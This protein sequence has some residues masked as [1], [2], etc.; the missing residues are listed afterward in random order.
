MSALL[1][2][3]GTGSIG[4]FLVKELIKN[5]VDKEIILFDLNPNYKKIKEISNQVKVVCGD[6][7]IW[8]DLVNIV[9]KYEVS[10]IF[11][12]AAILSSESERS[13]LQSMRVNIKGTINILEVA[14]LFNINKV[15]FPSTISTYG[16]NAVEPVDENQIQQ[17]TNIY[18]V[19]KVF[20]ELWGLYYYRKYRID[21][22]SVRFPRIVNPGRTGSGAA[23][24]P[25]EL[26]EKVALEE[27]YKI[28]LKKDYKIPIL[29]IKD[30]IKSLMLLYEAKEVKTRI[31]NLSALV[32]DAEEILRVLKKYKPN[33]KV[34]FLPQS[35]SSHLQIPFKFNS[36][37]IYRELGWEIEYNTDKMVKDF[38]EY[39]NK[40]R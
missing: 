15:I 3:G 30:A 35:F 12:L 34:E 29:Y 11:H 13:P 18:G 19:T 14:K 6:V 25:S 20:D 21:F 26:I 17:P 40:N 37:K 16:L 31:Y 36:E 1:I 33:A 38:I 39:V 28:E 5:K 32:P 9:K 24:F 10:G 22:R 7:S 27:P 4:S 8:S 23:L 2:T